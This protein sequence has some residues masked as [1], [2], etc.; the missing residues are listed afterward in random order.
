MKRANWIG[1]PQVFRLNQ[2]CRVL[3]DAFGHNNYLVGSSLS[4]REFR[5]VDIRTILDDED[6]QK[7]FPGIGPTRQHDARWSLF[8]SAISQW[9]SSQT[10]L[11]IDYQIQSRTEANN[12]YP[13]QRQAVGIFLEPRNE[14]LVLGPPG[15]HKFPRK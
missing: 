12:L 3:V 13:G 6:F 4:K 9:L 5:D 10:E 11:S 2:A 7:M 8:C 15:S 1:A 14:D